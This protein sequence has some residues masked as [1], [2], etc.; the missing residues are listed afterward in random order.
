MSNNYYTILLCVIVILLPYSISTTNIF[1]IS[2]AILWLKDT[3]R[4]KNSSIIK[5]NYKYI[6]PFILLFV[7]Y[8]ASAYFSSDVKVAL[9]TLERRIPVLL[10]PLII[11]TLP[12]S[13]KNVE[14]IF[15]YFILSIAACCIIAL[16]LTIYYFINNQAEYYLEKALWYLPQTINFHAPYLALYLVISNILCAYFYLQK[17]KRG[18][19]L[20]V[21]ILNNVFLFLIS[22]RAALAV[23]LIFVV[24]LSSYYFYKNKGS[25]V[26][27]LNLF[28]IGA[29]CY[30]AYVYIPYLHTKI[31]KITEAAYGV[32]H[33]VIAAEAALEVIKNNPLF[34]VGLGDVQTEL[35][36]KLSDSTYAN[37]NVHNQYLHELMTYGLTGFALFLSVFI[38]GYYIAFTYRDV[39]FS[40]FLSTFLILFL[41]EVILARYQ[42]IVLFSVFYPLFLNLHISKAPAR[43]E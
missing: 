30:L 29:I 8:V 18:L 4:G 20:P 42:G 7:T 36:S 9:S 32:N 38:L 14:T 37:L 12:F 35:N 31:S 43:L 27:I 34:G 39:F 28:V 21:F 40:L 11:C 19:I 5:D 26:T 3:L 22:S 16:F 15:C 6:L 25:L 2:L 1:I 41:T 13:R 10:L 33:R 23:N 17:K 24:L